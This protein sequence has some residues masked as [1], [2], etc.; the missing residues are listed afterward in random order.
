VH[1]R[2]ALQCNSSSQ[3]KACAALHV[4][5]TRYMS[6][7]G[8]PVISLLKHEAET[9]C[10]QH[11]TERITGYVFMHMFTSQKQPCA[12]CLL[13]ILGSVAVMGTCFTAERSSVT[14]GDTCHVW[15]VATARPAACVQLVL[16]RGFPIAEHKLGIC[17]DGLYNGHTGCGACVK[18]CQIDIPP[19]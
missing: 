6:C 5:T 8:R 18:R 11:N 7:Q 14:C 1:Q 4:G 15:H 3:H 10:M 17:M 2:Q 19:C 9:N 16:Q 13:T 12:G